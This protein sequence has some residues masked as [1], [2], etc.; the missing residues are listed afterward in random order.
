M[1]KVIIAGSRQVA[2]PAN[3]KL[4]RPLF[5]TEICWIMDRLDECHAKNAFTEVVSGEAQGVDR[6]GE[7]WSA[8]KGIPIAPFPAR[9]KTLGKPAG[10]IRNAEMAEYADML[11]AFWDGYSTGTKNMIDEMKKANKPCIIF[12]LDFNDSKAEKKNDTDGSAT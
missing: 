3:P 1:N 8:E 7:L 4:K 11:V 2:N 12:T 6:T 10:P 5:Y 9:W